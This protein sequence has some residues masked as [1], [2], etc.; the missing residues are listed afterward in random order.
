MKL[1][2]SDRQARIVI[3]LRSAPTL[4]VNLLGANFFED[5]VY[6]IDLENGA[7]YLVKR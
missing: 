7:M 3:E 2:K 6:T 5:F 1:T 4:R